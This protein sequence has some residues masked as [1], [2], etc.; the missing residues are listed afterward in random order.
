MLERPELSANARL[1][2]HELEHTRQAFVFG[3]LMPVVYV[4]ASAMA[5]ARGGHWYRDNRLEVA[6]RAAGA[7]VAE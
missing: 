5:L 4:I 6:A 7:S 2:A 1:I 3:P